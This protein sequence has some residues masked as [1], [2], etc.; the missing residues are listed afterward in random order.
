MTKRT[1]ALALACLAASFLASA[2]EAQAVYN[3]GKCGGAYT[4]QGGDTIT[5]VPGSNPGPESFWLAVTSGGGNAIL[6]D[7]SGGTTGG[8]FVLRQGALMLFPV[9][10]TY[11]LLFTGASAQIL[12]GGTVLDRPGKPICDTG[13]IGPS[14]IKVDKLL[15][16]MT[17]SHAQGTPTVSVWAWFQTSRITSG[18]ITYTLVSTPQQQAVIDPAAC[19]GTDC[20]Q[21]TVTNYALKNISGGAYTL[22]E[23]DAGGSY[24]FDWNTA[25]PAPFT[26]TASASPTSGTAPVDVTFAASASGG[27]SGYKWAWTLG[28]GATSAKQGFTHT[29]KSGG[30]FIWKVTV[31]DLAGQTCVKSGQ[32]Q[33]AS[34]LSAT[35]TVT[36]RQGNA[37]LTST[38]TASAKG[39]KPPYT[40]LWDFQ[41]G[42][43]ADTAT[44]S[45][46]FVSTGAYDCS[47]DGH[48]FGREERHGPGAR[49]RGSPHLPTINT[50]KPVSGAPS[51]TLKVM[52]A[53]F[54]SGCSRE[55]RRAG[56]FPGRFQEHH[57]PATQGRKPTQGP[58]PQ[59]H[60]RLRDGDQPR[61]RPVGLFHLHALESDGSGR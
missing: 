19:S 41:D 23:L 47:G 38:F 53:D 17:Q 16:L 56:H 33:I 35:A 9:T 8:D 51:F 48:R 30:K 54:Q 52:G 36:P 20:C 43:T 12:F 49:L 59:G 24:N 13:L 14:F 28:D 3:G 5:F 26:C 1:F 7:G 21:P 31:T 61:R 57:H 2:A 60:A 10:Q 25:V 27:S 4:L 22:F 29:Y 42:N 40:Y 37:P 34:P 6:S 18:N 58:L 45:H 50:V 46:T 44:A 39:A 55:R 32:L 11:S 15:N